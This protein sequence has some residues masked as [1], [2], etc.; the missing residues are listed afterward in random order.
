MNG[1]PDC[2]SITTWGK[3]PYRNSQYTPSSEQTFL[4]Y[5]QLIIPSKHV[6]PKTTHRSWES[7]SFRTQ[8][9]RKGGERSREQWE[10]KATTNADDTDDNIRPWLS[11]FVAS[12]GTAEARELLEG[13]GLPEWYSHASDN[14][15]E[16]SLLPEKLNKILSTEKTVA[17]DNK[18]VKFD[19][20]VREKYNVSISTSKGSAT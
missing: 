1:I 7:Y 18:L 4:R 13:A 17:N 20:W 12:H 2:V 16:W 3:S 15:D 6:L 5:R 14:I 9:A 11:G 10:Y 19:A 8:D